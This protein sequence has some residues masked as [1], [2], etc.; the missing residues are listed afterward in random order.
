[1]RSEMS[2]ETDQS[3]LVVQSQSRAHRSYLSLKAD[4]NLKTN[5]QQELTGLGMSFIELLLYSNKF[6]TDLTM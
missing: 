3:F 4:N 2:V 6:S 1:M 5:I